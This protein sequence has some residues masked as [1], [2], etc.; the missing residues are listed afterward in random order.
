MKFEIS[1]EWCM[2]AAEREANQQLLLTVPPAVCKLIKYCGPPRRPRGNRWV[3]EVQRYMVAAT[4]QFSIKGDG[5]QALQRAIAQAVQVHA[6]LKQFSTKTQS[7][8]V[9][10]KRRKRVSDLP[11]GIDLNNYRGSTFTGYRVQWKD[12]SGKYNARVFPDLPSAVKFRA[13][14]HHWAIAYDEAQREKFIELMRG[15]GAAI[16]IR[17]ALLADEIP[18][19]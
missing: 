17:R 11:T 5:N 19:R 10:R 9:T 1:K 13:S 14:I 16:K 15:L 12:P 2:A 18:P 7:A 4:W 6:V 3:I 8:F